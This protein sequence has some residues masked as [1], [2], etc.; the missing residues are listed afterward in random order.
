MNIKDL[1]KMY[2]EEANITDLAVEELRLFYAGKELK[3]EFFIYTYEIKDE[4]T[5]QVMIRKL[6]N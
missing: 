1:K 5:I 4:M 3:D 2:L 6:P